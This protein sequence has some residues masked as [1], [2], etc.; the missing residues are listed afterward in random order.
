MRLYDPSGSGEIVDFTFEY[1]NPA[2]Q[3]MMHM[4]EVPTVT[5]KQQWPQ[6]VAHGT[7]KPQNPV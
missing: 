3:R 2:A 7:P 1:L 4:P 5:H 6:S